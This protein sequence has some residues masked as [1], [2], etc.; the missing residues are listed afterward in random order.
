M[1]ALD[2]QVIEDVT[3]RLHA[4][5]KKRG[6]YTPPKYLASGGSAAIFQ[7]EGSAGL[8]AF[9]VFDPKFFDS[10]SGEAERRRLEIQRR[11]IGHEC[12][13]LVQTY[14]V[15]EAEGTAFMEM[16][17]VPWPD[18][19]ATLATVPDEHVAV[20]LKQLVE[21]ARFLEEQGIVHRDIKPENIKI[22]PDFKSLKLLDLGVARDIEAPD[23]TDAA[24]TD[25]GNKRPFLAT[26]QYSSPEYLF[27]L[28]EPS[29]KLWKGLNFY[30]IGAV[31]HDLIMKVPLFHLEM[32]AG[33]RWLVTKAVLMKAPSF[34]DGAAERL[35]ELKALAARCLVKDLETRLQIVRWEDFLLVGSFD[36]LS[37]LRGR[38]A[39]GSLNAGP[40]A[41]AAAEKGLLFDKTTLTK[42]FVE[43][44]R[45]ELISVCG[46]QLPFVMISPNTAE[47]FCKY[48]FD[49][50]NDTIISCGL[51]FQW[52]PE[53]YNRVANIA[54]YGTLASST[55]QPDT[56]RSVSAPICD[57]S[58]DGGIEEAVTNL[59]QSIA[60]II[61][62]ALDL[63]ETQPDSTKLHG[64]DLTYNLQKVEKQ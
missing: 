38:L 17:L 37:S 21:A 46:K 32:S 41:K 45:T 1:P 48:Q 20:L 54:L 61:G 19:N 13:S 31:L 2:Q 28:D 10:D 29:P 14:R 44:V 40:L 25:H 49:M 27:R 9:K 50:C 58:I 7:S 59:T 51:E 42:K 60:T 30:Q 56:I 18:L 34:T 33:N 63:L 55:E 36:P 12:T 3:A 53:P 22:S 8:R 62:A 64:I 39:K 35:A 15:E 6:G 4:Y 16:E 5:L 24:I 43:R 11:L 23:E 52:Q 57:I 47:E 26:A